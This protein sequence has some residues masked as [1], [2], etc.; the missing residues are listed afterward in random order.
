LPQ[1]LIQSDF[2]TSASRQDISLT[3]RRNAHLL[4]H[5]ASAFRQA[6]LDFTS[7]KDFAYKWPA[8]L[9]SLE[10]A[11]GTF[12]AD[13]PSKI[14]A[15][16][17]GHAVIRTR[18]NRLQP[19]TDVVIPTRNFKDSNGNVLLDHVDIDPF[20]S[21]HY[22]R[23][24]R[25]YLT[26][27]G[28]KKMTFGVI[29]RLLQE[30]LKSPLS[31]MKSKGLS[32]DIHSRMA[33]FLAQF[34]SF[35]GLRSLD[36]LPLQDGTWI[37]PNSGPVFFPSTKGISI[38]SGLGFRILDSSATTNEDRYA[39]FSS[40]GVNEIAVHLAR[41]AAFEKNSSVFEHPDIAQS[42]E[43]LVFLYR[44][45]QF[46]TSGEKN[47]AM[48][49]FSE[50][51]HLKMTSQ[52]DCYIPSNNPYGPKLLLRPTDSLPS[53]TVPFVHPS[54]LE[55]TPE[56]PSAIHSS[57]IQWLQTSVGVRKT[58]RLIAKD[59]QSL[60]STWDYLNKHRP[61]KLLGFLRYAWGDEGD[62]IN[63][64]ESLRQALR[65]TDASRLCDVDLPGE[66]R[67]HEAYLPFPNL[68][69]Q[70]AQFVDSEAVFPFL[71]LEGDSTVEQLSSNWLFLH[72]SL[73]V[74]KDEDLD[75]LL[76][77]LKWLKTSNPDASRISDFELIFSLYSA[78]HSKL[79]GTR[80]K[81]VLRERIR[82]VRTSTNTIDKTPPNFPHQV[83]FSK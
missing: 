8:Y 21:D 40:M 75:F 62:L 20:I 79:V 48:H 65:E 19:I 31:R 18:H 11:A 44:T 39:F 72:T 1:F 71:H 63:E 37:S 74:R 83:I 2:D 43:H 30:D 69:H 64:N 28:L 38:P 9:P 73:G 3:S 10:E 13:L 57:W 22:L 81:V 35:Q 70:C 27:Y 80:D 46:R 77:I 45:H 34:H 15:Q 59:G 6:V 29:L 55:D 36:L 32:D 50:D 16:L 58:L 76:D 24:D 67:L 51:G 54:Y 42:K 61:Q 60:S 7:D 53:M 47:K 49:I 23:K 52:Q 82:Y 33:K 68:T 12:W 25:K 66:C 14:L 17:S 41:E 5:V 26:P 78:I 56:T 4:D